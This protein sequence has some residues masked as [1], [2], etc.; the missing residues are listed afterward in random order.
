MLIVNS[1]PGVDKL[2]YAGDQEFDTLGDGVFDV[3]D[4]VAQALITFPQWEV[5]HGEI[6]PAAK[7]AKP[8]KPAKAKQ[9]KA[10]TA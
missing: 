3:P 6:R 2:G 8:A 10:A 7:P 9:D 4:E 5:Y 1:D